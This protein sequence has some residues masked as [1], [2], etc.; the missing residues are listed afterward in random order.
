MVVQ[1]GIVLLEYGDI[2]N[3]R[4]LTVPQYKH[5]VR[6][7]QIAIVQKGGNG[8][9]ALID[10]ASLP[11]RYKELVRAHLGG[12]PEQLVKEQT[13]EKHLTLDLAD[14]KHLDELQ[15]AGK[16]LGQAKAAKLKE[17]AKVLRLLA[18]MDQVRKAGG[19]D[20]IVQRYGLPTMKLKEAIAAHVK[21]MKVAGKLSGLPT[22]FA[23]LEARKRDYLS[24]R[25]EGKPGAS[26][27]V[28]GGA[29]NTNASKLK[30]E[31][32]RKALLT[33]L[34]RPQNISVRRC[35]TDYNNLAATLGWPMVTSSTVHAFKAATPNA[36]SITLGAR[37][38]GAYHDT[39]NLVIHREA[40]STPTYMWVV[41]GD[42][43][44]LYYQAEERDAKGRLKRKQWLRKVVA[45]VLDAHTWYPVGFAIGNT[46]SAALVQAAM[47]N[48]VDHM[49][50]LTGEYLLPFQVQSDRF[51]IDEMTAFYGTVAD[52]FT[53]AAVGNARAKVIEPY[54]RRH[55]EQYVQPY[56]LNY[57]G[58]NIDG[59]K[60]NQPNPD[61]LD[62][63]KNHFPDEA[64]VVEAITYNINKERADKAEAYRAALSEAGAGLKTMDRL[65]YLRCFGVS[66]GETHS[67]TNK[68]LI[69][70][71][72]GTQLIY[73]RPDAAF[74]DRIGTV[75]QLAFDPADLTSV[76]A[77]DRTGRERWLVPAWEKV[78]AAIMDHTPDTWMRLR[79][80]KRSKKAISQRDIDQLEDARESTYALGMTPEQ[81]ALLRGR[82]TLGGQH[83]HL[84]QGTEPEK[85]KSRKKALP[86]PEQTEVPAAIAEM[87]TA[88]W[89]RQKALSGL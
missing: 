33:L 39:F 15:V 7:G 13:I 22:A 61:A 66:T 73:N 68:G 19:N 79:D 64:G 16:H 50:A 38:K 55:H 47:K 18:E 14:G 34:A 60:K 74:Q 3:D 52:Y 6:K 48:A 23:R 45:V 63:A 44:E 77:M 17:A 43:Y 62:R 31:Q 2:V 57:G 28:H 58:H 87:Y 41:D 86:K 81:E 29:G 67:L 9:P 26:C 36:R 25:A 21:R 20:A 46:E 40:P 78:P 5:A 8:H 11:E 65:E 72:A 24:A 88:E 42:V 89:I 71:F 54:F 80:L 53:P 59:L 1:E 82:F 10:W 49:K 27:L 85:R 83:K 12:E 51:S 32:A 35:T 4:C 69:A 70:R 75:Y 84:V 56:Y 30:N 76:M 37:G